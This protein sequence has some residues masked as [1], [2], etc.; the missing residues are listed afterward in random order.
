MPSRD[1]AMYATVV[2]A[3]PP[4]AIRRW[5]SISVSETTLRGLMPSNVAAFTTRL[6]SSTGPSRAGANGSTAITTIASWTWAWLDRTSDVP[7]RARRGGRG[8][9]RRRLR[10]IGLAGL[11]RAPDRDRQQTR[12]T[13]QQLERRARLGQAHH[14]VVRRAVRTLRAALSHAT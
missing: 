14:R 11:A 1:T 4:A 3:T 10:P 2:I 13:A 6:R 8:P 9:P 7:L 5:N 12:Y